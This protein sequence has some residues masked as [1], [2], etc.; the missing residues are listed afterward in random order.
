MVSV[1]T[2]LIKIKIDKKVFVFLNFI[3][4]ESILLWYKRYLS[5]TEIISDTSV[6]VFFINNYATI[7]ILYN[8]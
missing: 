7:N 6:I 3:C 5:I 2:R 4:V 8:V 1:T